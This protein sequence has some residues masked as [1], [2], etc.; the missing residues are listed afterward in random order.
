AYQRPVVEIDGPDLRRAHGAAIDDRREEGTGTLEAS[1]DG[2]EGAA[3]DDAIVQ[4]EWVSV[5]AH[6]RRGGSELAPGVLPAAARRRGEGEEQAT[7]M[8]PVAGEPRH[9]RPAGRIRLGTVVVAQEMKGEAQAEGHPVPGIRARIDEPSAFG[10]VHD[11]A[12][13]ERGPHLER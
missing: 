11:V 1:A 7:R 13:H 9:D 8:L 2:R 3:D 12:P 10:R 6:V 4:R 5:A